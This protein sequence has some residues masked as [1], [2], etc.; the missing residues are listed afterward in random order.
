MK[1]GMIGTGGIAQRHLGVLGTIPD[2]EIVGHVSHAPA[3]AVAQA[4][5]WGGEPF[6]SIE[7][8]LDRQR[9]EVVWVCVTPDRHGALE[10][11]LVRRRLPFFVEKPLSADRATAEEIA[12]RLTPD[13][14]I[15]AVGYKL[16]ALDTLDRARALL[17][18]RPPRM[19]LAAWHDSLPPPAWWRRGAQSGG[20][21]VEQA[22]HL[23]DL[24]RH[25]VG[26][27]TVL[28]GLG[29]QWPRADE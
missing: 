18:E 3:R 11:E 6:T 1:I 20:Q 19:V 21:V 23:L 14:P 8:L 27:A 25:L 17:A 24:A 16:R 2:L 4:A 7:E 15:V 22:T 13:G 12:T 29:G 26:E 10:R 9:P 5:Q 28:A